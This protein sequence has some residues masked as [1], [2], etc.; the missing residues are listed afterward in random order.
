MNYGE[1]VPVTCIETVPGDKIRLHASDLIRA[2]PMV[3]SPFVRAKQH[4]DAWFVP[5]RDLWHNFDNFITQREQP[6]SS[7]LKQ[8]QYIPHCSLYHLNGVC[9][10]TGYN[11]V[12]GRTIKTRSPFLLQ[13]L[14][15]GV[16]STPLDASKTYPSVNLWR[17]AAYNYIWYNEYRQQY[18]DNGNVLNLSSNQSPAALFNFD[19]LDCYTEASSVVDSGRLQGMVQMRYRCWKKDLFTGL[20]P[21]TQFGSVSVVNSSN[22]NDLLLRVVNPS[23]QVQGGDL[24]G[25][26]GNNNNTALYRNGSVVSYSS[27]VQALFNT[28]FDVLSL[29]RSEAIQIWRENALRAGNRVSDNM[30]AHY[31]VESDFR[32]HRPVYLGSVTSPLNIGDINSTASTGVGTND[33]VG[34]VAGKGLSSLDDKVFT[35]DSKDF[36]VIMVIA[37]VLPEA[38]YNASGIDRMNQLVEAE[39]YFIPE[40]ENIGLEAVS[41]QVFASSSVDVSKVIGYAPRYF[42]YKQKLD[43]VFGDFMSSNPGASNMNAPWAAPK[44][45]VYNAIINYTSAIPLSVLYVNPAIFDVNFTVGVNVSNQFLCDMYFDVA[46]VRPMSVIGLPFS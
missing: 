7:A 42:G 2:I 39:D 9:N 16:T 41:S 23:A 44:F 43:L 11:D 29:R 14:G 10:Q 20:L 31:G 22:Y 26:T 27:P 24:L 32:D 34:D 13:M 21:S 46:A 4:L 17:L 40:Y 18:F 28:N 25:V 38:E 5:Y 33:N 12:V 37:S 45:D 30:R 15:Y 8:F 35:F 3:T 36:G 19:D 6:V 1:L